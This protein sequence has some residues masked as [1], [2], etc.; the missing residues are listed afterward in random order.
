ML[1]LFL[2]ASFLYNGKNYFQVYGISLAKL[3]CFVNFY[4]Y[5]QDWVSPFA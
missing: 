3:F 1:C 2:H 5:W 4:S